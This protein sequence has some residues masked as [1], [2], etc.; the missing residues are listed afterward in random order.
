MIRQIADS[1][2]YSDAIL[3][4]PQQNIPTSIHPEI[5]LPVC[6]C[7]CFNPFEFSLFSSSFNS[8]FGLFVG[9]QIQRIFNGRWK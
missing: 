7:V 8:A 9:H 2:R 5:L 4:L 1:I 6:V 3:V